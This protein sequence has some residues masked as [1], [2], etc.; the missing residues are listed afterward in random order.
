MVQTPRAAACCTTGSFTAGALTG[1]ALRGEVV[2]VARVELLSARAN[3]LLLGV[4]VA[5][6]ARTE[7]ALLDE[8]GAGGDAAG[9]GDPDDRTV[10][11]DVLGL[12][13]AAGAGAAAAV[14]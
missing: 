9:V 10:G 6:E 5:E 12:G 8:R 1:A 3:G 11:A 14:V 13:V 2:V 4:A 7:V